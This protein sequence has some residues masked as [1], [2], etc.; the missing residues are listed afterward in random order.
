MLFGDEI[1][2]KAGDPLSPMDN[3]IAT[4][5]DDE[6]E[7]VGGCVSDMSF[8]AYVGAAMSGLPKGAAEDAITSNELTDVMV[9]NLGEVMNILTRLVISDSSDHLRYEK[10][11]KPGDGN[12]IAP[13][14]EPIEPVPFFIEIPKYGSGNLTFYIP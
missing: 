1:A 13:S 7:V 4:Y 2:V 10:I 11:L 3:V 12:S 14:L 9:G 5:L 6:N 8:A